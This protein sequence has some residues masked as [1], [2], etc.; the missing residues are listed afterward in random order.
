MVDA[1]GQWWEDQEARFDKL[2]SPGDLVDLRKELIETFRDAL[3][4]TPLLDPFAIRGIVA[5]WWGVSLPDFKALATHGYQGLIEAWVTTVLD[6]LAEEKAK[7]NPLDHKVARALLPEYLDTLTG[8]E[9]DVAELDSTIKAA[10]ASDDEESDGEPA[11]DALSPTELKKLKSKLTAAKKQLKAEKA[12]F[13]DRLATASTALDDTSARQ[14]VL[15]AM[16]HDLLAEANDRITR[17]RRTVIAAFEM[18]WDKYQT[19]L[20]MLEAERDAAAAKLA[21]FFKELGY[22]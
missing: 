1:I 9:S 20:S 22:E 10:T 13:A 12:A 3:A 18:W 8:L 6:A 4:S 14:V 21:R 17:H 11:E 16:E 5:S 2:Q 7:V 15:D 19:P